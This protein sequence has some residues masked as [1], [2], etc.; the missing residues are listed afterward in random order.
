MCRGAVRCCSWATTPA[1]T[2]H[3]TRSR[4]LARALRLDRRLRLN[5][6][7]VSLALPWGLDVGDMFGH[8]ALPAKITIQVLEPIDLLERFG[9]GPDVDS[10]YEAITM[11]MQETL[12]DLSAQRR[13]PIIG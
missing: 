3:P 4:S 13:W 8:L 12:D 7:P 1:G 6:L 5:V 11:L 2:W 9:P 10:V